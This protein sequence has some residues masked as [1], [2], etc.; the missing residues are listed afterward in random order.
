MHS[1]YVSNGEN[2]DIDAIRLALGDTFFTTSDITKG[3]RFCFT[4][5][6]PLTLVCGARRRRMAQS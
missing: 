2:Q 1:F 4:L 6:F 5:K 3:F